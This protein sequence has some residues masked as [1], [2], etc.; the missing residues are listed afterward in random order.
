MSGTASPAAKAKE[1]RLAHRDKGSARQ[2]EG[3]RNHK[4]S[5][6]QTAGADRTRLRPSHSS[7]RRAID[8]VKVGDAAM[9]GGRMQDSER[10][11]KCNEMVCK[12]SERLGAR[13]AKG[14]VQGQ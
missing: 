3:R 8:R 10:R 11:V 2:C 1:K 14:M 12:D 5:A 13:T 6:F 9:Q 7:A 4:T